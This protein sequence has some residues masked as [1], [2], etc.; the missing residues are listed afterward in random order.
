MKKVRKYIALLL[1]L[2]MILSVCGCKKSEKVDNEATVA[3]TATTAPVKEATKAPEPT[4]APLMDTPSN[5]R[6]ASAARSKVNETQ[7][8]V[9]STQT[10]DGKFSPFFGTSGY[11]IDVYGMTQ[12][13][14]IGNDE[15]GAPV[16]GVEEPVAAWKYEM[17][18]AAD[19][20]S[21]TYKFWLK[22]G[23]K[24]SDGHQM[25]IN[26][27]LFNMYVYLDPKYDGSS[28]MY[29]LPIDGLKA[30]QTQILD[31]SAADAKIAEFTEAAAK[32]VDDAMAG[33]GDAEVV[34][35]LWDGVK[36]SVTAD[37]DVLIANA[38]VPGDLGMD[39]P[40]DYLDTAKESIILFYTS[41]CLGKE[42]ISYKDGAYVFDESTGLSADQMSSYTAQ[43]YIDAS[44]KVIE[45]NITVSEFDSGFGYDVVGDTKSYYMT[46]LKSKFLEENKGTVKSIRGITTGKEVCEDGVER[47]TLTVVVNAVD[48]TA[49]WK[50][51]F[52]IAPMHY[53]AGQE[54]HDA[55]NGVDNFGVE[56]SSDEFI[57]KLKEKNGLPMGAGPYKVTDQKGSENPTADTFYENGICY[58]M[59]NDNYIMSAPKIKYI[60]Y[61]TIASGSELDS[62]LTGEVHYSD[63]T[64]SADR[65]NLI[66][67]DPAYKALDYILVDNLGY[68]YIGIN[69]TLIPNIAE[70]RALFSAM[71]TSLTLNSY[72]GGLAAVIHRP[73]SQVSWAYPDGCTAYYP[74][75]ETAATSKE[76]FIKAGFIDNGDGTVSKA[77]GTKATY[78]FTV[79]SDTSSHPAGQVF[80]KA[81]EVLEKIGV[82]V[83]IEVDNNVLS[84]LQEEIV[85]VWAAAW[86]ATIDP[87][88]FQV[89]YSDPTVNQAGSPKNYGLY[90]MF[91]NGTEEEKAA[92]TELNS[93]IMTGRSTLVVDERKPVYEAALDKVMEVA[94]ELPTYQRKN[95]YAYNKE[96]IDPETLT[97]ADK[98]TPYKGP[99]FAWWNISMIGD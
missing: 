27:V 96:V 23:I 50:L 26:D 36:K 7:P 88:M 35:K 37:N 82:E 12:I 94:V 32:M 19:N 97:P 67:S 48:P 78:T 60:R 56:F 85:P 83:I 28:T 80:L 31:E 47:E 84:K 64:A 18:V 39:G 11:D 92:L 8:L 53:Y 73:M 5:Y 90:H 4:S 21:S 46:E 98:I 86:G 79:P 38:Y 76:Y 70:R 30:Y 55:A 57:L 54:Y 15:L 75:D 33:T 51:S 91:T 59:A 52:T 3:P 20:N 87:D 65:I 17:T 95:M 66:T 29:S 81:Q 42:F 10:L 24:F 6:D 58:F 34:Q 71:D 13:S 68:G 99:L 14:M 16:A 69:A 61:K 25:D 22:N 43:D 93:L 40:D 89:Y 62:V 1:G 63:P 77:D 45:A 44:M 41:S 49:I 74:F 2:L 72:P 9:I